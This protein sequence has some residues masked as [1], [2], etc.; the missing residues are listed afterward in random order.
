VRDGHPWMYYVH[1]MIV[2]LVTLVVVRV[3]HDAM[4]SF[5]RLR[6]RWLKKLPSPRCTTVLVEGIPTEWCSDA[7]LRVFFETC[8]KPGAVVEATVVKNSP[9]LERLVSEEARYKELLHQAEAELRGYAE[10]QLPETRPMVND[11]LCCGPQVDA[12]THYQEKLLEF[13]KQVSIERNAVLKLSETVSGVNAHTAFVTFANRRQ[14][15]MAKDLSFGSYSSEWVVST[16]PPASDI[17]W[18][19]LKSPAH[20]RSMSS[21]LGYTLVVALYILFIPIC[22]VGTNLSQAVHMGPLQAVWESFAPGL[23]LIIFLSFLPTVMLLIFRT[24]FYLKAD[25]YAQH[26]LQV[27]Y[28]YFMVFF[29]ILVTAIG[30]SLVETIARVLRRPELSVTLLARYLPGATKFYVDFMMLQWVTHA[31]QFTR[32]VNLLKFIVFS[33]FYEPADA[34]KM[35]EPEDQDFYGIGSRSA[36]FTINVVIGIV[37]STL[38]PLIAVLTFLNFLICRI[39]YGYLIVFAEVKKPDLG[40]IFFVTQ[41]KHVLVGTLIYDGL[42]IGVLFFRAASKAPMIIAM[43]SF[44]YSLYTFKHFHEE[45]LWEQLPF[46]EVCFNEE[47][48]EFADD[49]MP[50]V[51]PEFQEVESLS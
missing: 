37:F 35:S 51:Q 18:A 32:Y 16:P 11:W 30:T 28:F 43:P 17:R 34:K 9:T 49:G 50:Y 12:I 48:F 44:A 3:T 26:K 2:N 21:A 41:I 1:A 40:G 6:C 14:A 27:W 5:M 19:D 46:K 47:D 31:L 25:A 22:V 10:N 13:N 33:S 7:K 36:R 24:C 42:M 23:S 38:S 15:G 29:V 20:T 45:F 8:L 39:F 4:G